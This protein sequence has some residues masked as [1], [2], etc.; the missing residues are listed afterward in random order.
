MTEL[1]ANK[2]EVFISY[3]T[4]SWIKKGRALVSS[5]RYEEALQAYDKALTLNPDD[6][7]SWHRKS[8]ELYKLCRYEEARQAYDRAIELNPNDFDT[9]QLK[10]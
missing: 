8:I 2:R 7:D 4:K 3:L 6:S 9:C 10:W 1:N 5:G